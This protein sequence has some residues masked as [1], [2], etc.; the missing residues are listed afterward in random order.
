ME[1]KYKQMWEELEGWARGRMVDYKTEKEKEAIMRVVEIFN[2]K[3]KEIKEKHFPPLP[4]SK[5]ILKYQSHDERD[6]EYVRQ[7]IKILEEIFK[8]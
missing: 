6:M 7:I 4:K 3:I 1:N 2:L 8:R 5:L